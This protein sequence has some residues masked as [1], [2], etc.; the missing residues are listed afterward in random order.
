MRGKKQEKETTRL[1]MMS[2]PSHP[3]VPLVASLNM[4]G[5]TRQGRDRN[6]GVKLS[7]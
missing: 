4:T 5:I 7:L 3:L 1:T 2:P 6:E